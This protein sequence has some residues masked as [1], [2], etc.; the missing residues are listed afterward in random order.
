MGLPVAKE[1]DGATW[2]GE[3]NGEGEAG[4]SVAETDG[5]IVDNTSGDDEVNTSGDEVRMSCDDEVSTIGDEVSTSGDDFSTEDTVRDS[6]DS[7]GD[8]ESVDVNTSEEELVSSPDGE[9]VT[10]LM[11]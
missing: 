4:I 1:C 9:E 7:D 10:T 11:S 8:G 5:C 6:G 3:G 2:E